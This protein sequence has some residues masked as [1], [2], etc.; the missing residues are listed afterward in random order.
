MYNQP[1]IKSFCITAKLHSM[2]SYIIFD[3]V[4]LCLYL[5]NKHLNSMKCYEPNVKSL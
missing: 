2:A 3:A 1:D 4:V 5:K